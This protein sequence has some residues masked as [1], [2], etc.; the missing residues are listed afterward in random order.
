MF[1]RIAVLTSGMS[2]A[3][4]STPAMA[5]DAQAG[6]TVYRRCV[7]CH[8]TTGAASIGPPLNG[9]VGRQAGKA[10]RYMYSKALASKSIVWDR[11]ALDRFLTRPQAL[12][13][14]TKMGFAG[15][16]NPKERHDLIAYLATLGK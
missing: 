10:P 2:L 13:P 12:V 9:I 16:S 5:Q 6:A 1:K 7:A 14:G 4:G 15:L 3:L 8:S 11:A